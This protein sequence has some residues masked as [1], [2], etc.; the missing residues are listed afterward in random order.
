[1]QIIALIF[2]TRQKGMPH[3]QIEGF[4]SF[5]FFLLHHFADLVD[6]CSS[7]L[8]EPKDF[9]TCRVQWQAPAIRL[10]WR[11]NFETMWVR[12]QLGGN[13]HSIGG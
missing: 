1:M 3:L 9:H 11:S 13:S 6:F 12:Y 2:T 10:I 7:L 8:N 4:L 5:I